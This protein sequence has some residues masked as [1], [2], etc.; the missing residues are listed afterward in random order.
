MTKRDRPAPAPLRLYAWEDEFI[1]PRDGTSIAFE[2]AQCMVDAIWAEMGLRF[3]P[4]VDCLPRQAR[5]TMAD[6]TRRSIRLPESSPSWRLLHEL[7]H[8]LSSAYDGISAGHGPVFVGLY[9]Q[10]LARPMR[11]PSE[12]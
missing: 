2:Q 9:A 7:V 4:K 12:E 1:G 3:A 8:A 6:A 5:C 10:M 11:V